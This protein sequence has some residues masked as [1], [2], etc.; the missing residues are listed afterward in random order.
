MS[1]HDVHATSEV[2]PTTP[3]VTSPAAVKNHRTLFFQ[4]DLPARL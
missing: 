3:N 4:G 1:R 2:I